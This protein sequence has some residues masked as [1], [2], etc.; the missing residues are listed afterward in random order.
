MHTIAKTLAEFAPNSQNYYVLTA[1]VRTALAHQNIPAQQRIRAG[2]ASYQ[3]RPRVGTD[4]ATIS[5]M[6]ARDGSGH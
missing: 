1:S 4:L 2:N 5:T 3:A 6:R